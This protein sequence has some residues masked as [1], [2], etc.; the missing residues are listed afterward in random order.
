MITIMGGRGDVTFEI[1]NVTSSGRP[2]SVRATCVVPDVP[3]VE[4]GRL[5]SCT[6]PAPTHVVAGSPYALT[7]RLSVNNNVF[8]IAAHTKVGVDQCPQSRFYIGSEEADGF[9]ELP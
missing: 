5:V 1:C 3:L 2:S 9:T 8:R 7:L 6:F 4:D